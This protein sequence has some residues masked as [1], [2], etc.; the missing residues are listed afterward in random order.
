LNQSRQAGPELQ[1]KPRIIWLDIIRGIALIAMAIYHF[2]WDLEFFGYIKAGTIFQPEWKYFARSIASTFIVLVGIGLVLAHSGG[3]RHRPFLIRLAKVTVA[4]AAISVISWYLMPGGFIFFGILH[5][6]ALG[7]VF[8]LLFLRLHWVFIA[9]AAA[10]FIIGSYYLRSEMFNA[11]IWYWLGLGEFLP[12]SFDYEPIFPW[13]GAMLI[14]M[15]MARLAQQH[16]GFTWLSGFNPTNIYAR[17][18]AFLGRL[19]YGSVFVVVLMT[20]GPDRT[21]SFISTCETNC[22]QSRDKAFCQKFCVCATDELKAQN[23]WD[24]I[25]NRSIDIATDKRVQAITRMCTV[26]NSN[27]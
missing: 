23:L 20:G 26:R 1:H 27:E 13:F 10:F 19:L 3:F 9:V 22:A 17:V 12:S 4:A 6:I 24:G 25:Q 21:A 16:G 18:L 2:T 11:P 15:V 14:G 5:S 7:S 8:A